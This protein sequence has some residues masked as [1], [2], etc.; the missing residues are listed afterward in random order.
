MEKA[1]QNVSPSRGNNGMVAPA[2]GATKTDSSLLELEM[3]SHIMKH[4]NQTACRE[5]RPKPIYSTA[6]HKFCIP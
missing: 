5:S 3:P 1:L 6:F 4:K 2:M